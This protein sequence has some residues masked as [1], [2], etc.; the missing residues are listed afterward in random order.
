MKLYV[1]L[2]YEAFICQNN[3]KKS[4]VIHCFVYIYMVDLYCNPS[5]YIHKK[6]KINGLN[7][8]NNA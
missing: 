2:P 7:L 8:Q 5:T 6:R 1:N 4:D 3:I